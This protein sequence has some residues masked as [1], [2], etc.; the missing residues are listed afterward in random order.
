[1]YQSTYLGL[2]LFDFNLQTSQ[3]VVAATKSGKKTSSSKIE[4]CV[5]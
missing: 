2:T 5:E 4:W 1:M 3:T